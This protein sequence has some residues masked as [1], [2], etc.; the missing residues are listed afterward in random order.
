MSYEIEYSKHA[1][2][3]KNKYNDDVFFTYV[4]IC[5]NNVS[6]RHPGPMFFA[7]GQAWNIIQQACKF[8]ADCESG[9]YKPKNRWVSPE[10]Y[11][12]NWRK[13]LKEATPLG[14]F[15]RDHFIKLTVAVKKGDFQETMLS[16]PPKDKKFYFD[17]ISKALEDPRVVWEERQWFEENLLQYSI[18]IEYYEDVELARD[19]F[20]DL[21]EIGHLYMSDLKGV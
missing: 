21:K 2:K 5:S 6:P 8:G 1:L 15:A 16:E 19:L 18:H 17:R 10:S 7:H 20:N 4:K 11:I 14:E 9:S 3:A 12:K 13:V